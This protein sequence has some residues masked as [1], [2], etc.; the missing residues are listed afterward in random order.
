MAHQEGKRVLLIFDGA[1]DKPVY[2]FLNGNSNA[3]GKRTNTGSHSKVTHFGNKSK[4]HFCLSDD[5]DANKVQHLIQRF[6]HLMTIADQFDLVLID[7]QTLA[8]SIAFDLFTEMASSIVLVVE[9]GETG[10]SAL[11][12]AHIRLGAMRDKVCGFVYVLAMQAGNAEFYNNTLSLLDLPL[13][14]MDTFGT[15]QPD[16]ANNHT[17]DQGTTNWN[18]RSQPRLSLVGNKLCV[19]RSPHGGDR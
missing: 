2:R 18:D 8:T 7:G 16:R 3:A 13:E 5:D 6:D 14:P 11:D 15:K 17:A 19:R 9:E 4:I 10:M 1:G 12:Q